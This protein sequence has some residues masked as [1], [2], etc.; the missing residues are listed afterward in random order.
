V[1]WYGSD[2][3]ER[4]SQ[5]GFSVQVVR[6]ADLTTAAEVER[7]GLDHDE[8]MFVCTHGAGTTSASARRPDRHSQSPA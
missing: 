6:T 3:T 1:R 4:L 7:F 2:I 8:T 5:A